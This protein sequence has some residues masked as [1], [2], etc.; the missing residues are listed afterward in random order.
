MFKRATESEKVV[1]E[2]VLSNGGRENLL[3]THN[4]KGL[5]PGGGSSPYTVDLGALDTFRLERIHL[6]PY[7]RDPHTFSW[8]LH[9]P[10]P[11]N[12]M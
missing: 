6:H 4:Q 1:P 10:P 5:S 12:K 11:Y 2:S 3:G 9:C 7:L 8:P